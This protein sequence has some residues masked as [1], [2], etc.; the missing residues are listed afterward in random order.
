M[1]LI[2]LV[3][4]LVSGETTFPCVHIL[5]SQLVLDVHYSMVVD[6]VPCDLPLGCTIVNSVSAR[7][8]PPH[9]YLTGATWMAQSWKLHLETIV[10]AVQSSKMDELHG[11]DVAFADGEYTPVIRLFTTR[12]HTTFPGDLQEEF[13]N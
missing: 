2:P 11:S 1:S 4:L 10:H 13:D 8:L 5:P 3:Q 12:A 6:L 9:N 7:Y